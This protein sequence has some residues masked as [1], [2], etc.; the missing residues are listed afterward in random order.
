MTPQLEGLGAIE[1]RESQGAGAG[2]TVWKLSPRPGRPWGLAWCGEDATAALASYEHLARRT[3]WG[4]V[5][6]LDPTG[7]ELRFHVGKAAWR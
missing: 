1:Y 5:R 2:Y 4:C 7:R 6:L 3:E